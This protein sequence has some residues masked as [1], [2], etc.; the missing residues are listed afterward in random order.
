MDML[1]LHTNACLRKIQKTYEKAE[2]LAGESK[3]IETNM[4]EEEIKHFKY[5]AMQIAQALY[6][7]NSDWAADIAHH[8]I[9]MGK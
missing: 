6:T 3:E 2:G 5:P 4:T 7:D 8:I 9:I 1:F